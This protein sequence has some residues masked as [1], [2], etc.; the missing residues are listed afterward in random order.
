MTTGHRPSDDGE[1][2]SA[3][4]PAVPGGEGG[5]GSARTRRAVIRTRTHDLIH[6]I[7]EGD[8][9][10]VESSVLALSQTRRIF[11]PLALLVGAFAMLFVGLRLLVTNWALM[12]VEI[13]P[14]MWIWIAM[15]DLKAHVLHDKSFHVVRGPVLIPIILAIALITTASFYLNAVFAFAIA[16]PGTPH[17][18]PAFKDARR[19]LAAVAAWGLSIG[20]ALGVATT[21]FPR[22]GKP[23]FTI[24][25]SI[26]VGVM[27]VT[28]V[29]V[30]ARM[31]GVRTNASQ[32]DKL[33]ATAVGGAIGAVIC[34]PPYLLARV[35]IL[36][37]GSKTFFVVGIVLIAVGL[38]LQSGA[39]GAVKAVKLSSKLVGGAVSG[40]SP[41][42]GTGPARSAETPAP[43]GSGLPV[44][45]AVPAVPTAD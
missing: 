16:K 31:I 11:A 29:S 2:G 7:R 12:L 22:W 41:A 27:M 33:S 28:Y 32:R 34:A 30:P 3:P 14:A 37:L 44:D 8:D 13:L 9:A 18:R 25:L 42:A 45:P 26:V 23:W 19:H 1:G 40:S 35:G 4:S 17:V 15:I 20:L 21:V 5:V 38:V 24:A 36:M 43:G 10:M 39:T 6:A